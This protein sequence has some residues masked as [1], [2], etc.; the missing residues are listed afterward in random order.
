VRLPGKRAVPIAAAL[1]LVLIMAA[2]LLLAQGASAR[3][4]VGAPL[5]QASST[6][7]T[8]TV[9]GHGEI[10]VAP[11]NATITLG[12]Q[13]RSADAQTALSDNS[14]KMSA[15]IGAVEGQGVPASHIQT[16]NFSIWY[17]SQQNVDNVTH[18]VTVKL[19]DVNKVG[20]VIDAGVAAGANSSWGVVFGI[21][22]LATVHAQALQAAVSD[23]RTRAD[24]MA[25]ALGV[26]ITGVGSASEVSFGNPV[27]VPYYAAPAGVPAAAPPT[28][29]Q[30]GQLRVSADISVVYTFG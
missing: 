23:A 27:P 18:E 12:V 7:H 19:D 17:D 20:A 3:G 26:S 29:V 10:I 28:P 25:A 9:A 13:T 1:G 15:V 24:T 16:S 2:V 6:G 21:K 22:D 8:V 4:N 5:K 14:T 30:L 11:D